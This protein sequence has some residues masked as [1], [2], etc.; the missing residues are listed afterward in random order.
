[1]GPVTVALN[2]GPSGGALGG[3]R[4]VNAVGG[5]ATFSLTLNRAGSYTLR[6][7]TPGVPGSVVTPAIGVRANR[8]VVTPPGNAVSAGG[9]FARTVGAVG[10]TGNVAPAFSGPVAA[11]LSAG[12]AGGALTG[13]L[14]VNLSGG[15]AQFP[16]LRLNKPGAS[17]TL[18]FE[19]GGL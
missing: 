10:L 12:P 15:V 7:S 18:R 13:T 16:N 14:T 2:T 5:L 4:T 9:S 11:R 3:P 1:R 6:C 17:Y 8:L 19:I